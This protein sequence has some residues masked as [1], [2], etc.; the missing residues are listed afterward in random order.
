MLKGR[1]RKCWFAFSSDKYLAVVSM[2][3]ESKSSLHG[4]MAAGWHLPKIWDY[5]SL[6]FFPIP[7]PILPCLLPLLPVICLTTQVAHSAFLD[8]VDLGWDCQ[9]IRVWPDPKSQ[10]RL[11]D[12]PFFQRQARQ[13]RRGSQVATCVLIWLCFLISLSLTANLCS[14][15]YELQIRDEELVGAYRERWNLRSGDE[16][17]LLAVFF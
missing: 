8:C 2:G 12:Q 10:C 17:G 13:P 7:A 4:V 1:G 5:S 9:A 16:G 6:S 15:G 14:S 11:T 3:W